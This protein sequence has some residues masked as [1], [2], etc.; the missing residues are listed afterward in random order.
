M[1]ARIHDEGT[2]AKV[3]ISNSHCQFKLEAST[4]TL[5]GFCLE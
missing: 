5:N 2:E 3:Y 1:Y 4:I